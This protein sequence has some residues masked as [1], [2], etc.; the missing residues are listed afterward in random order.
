MQ[1]LL[2]HIE[3]KL[4]HNYINDSASLPRKEALYIN[5]RISLMDHYGKIT[6]LTLSVLLYLKVLG[7]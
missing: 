1:M 2:E 5:Q 3:S 6:L 4:L 7:V